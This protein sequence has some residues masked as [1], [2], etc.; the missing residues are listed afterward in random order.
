MY[1]PNQKPISEFDPHVFPPMFRQLMKSCWIETLEEFLSVTGV[2]RRSRYTKPQILLEMETILSELNRGLPTDVLE[3][4][5]NGPIDAKSLGAEYPEELIAQYKSLGSLRN[6]SVIAPMTA[7]SLPTGFRLPVTFP[8]RDQGKRGICVACTIADF[9]Q[10]VTYSPDPLSVDYIYARCKSFD[11]YINDEGADLQTALGVTGRFGICPER[12]WRTRPNPAELPQSDEEDG[13]PR[14]SNIRPV[15]RGVIEDYKTKLTGA[16]GNV[17]MPIPVCVLAFESSLYSQ[18]AD[19]TGKWTLPLAG[20]AALPSGH[21][22][23]IIGYQDDPSVPGGGY[24]IARNSWGEDYA[25]DSPVDL[26]GHSLLPYEYIRRFCFEAYTGPEMAAEPCHGKNHVHSATQ[27]R[28]VDQVSTDVK[29]PKVAEPEQVYIHKLEYDLRER[30]TNRVLHAGEYVIAHPNDPN[31]VC[32]Y[33]ESNWKKFVA[34][35]YA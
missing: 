10:Y 34:N 33:T 6:D 19:L 22:M 3:I 31:S 14:V 26:P 16:D 30:I 7:P 15:L 23:L 13:F 28:N 9:T 17:P 24:F 11:G 5:L 29:T 1:I 12:I 35:G 4:W 32:A 20:E 25:C 8:I 2:L 27:A 21:A 18:A